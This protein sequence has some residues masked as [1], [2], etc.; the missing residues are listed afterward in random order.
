VGLDAGAV[1]ARWSS[2]SY[3]AIFHRLLLTDTDPASALDF[4]LSAGSAHLWN[5][6]QDVP[7]TAWEREIDDLMRRQ[8]ASLD[9]DERVRLFRE[10]QRIFSEQSPVLYFAAQ[11]LYVTTSARLAN[12]TPSRLRP[13]LLWSADTLQEGR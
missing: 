12:P 11:H 10:A 9:H 1:V 7:A 2:G 6:G 13:V 3:E 8:V 5:P 4:W